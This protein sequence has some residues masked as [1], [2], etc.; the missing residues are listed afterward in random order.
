MVGLGDGHLITYVVDLGGSAAGG[1]PSLVSKRKG[2]LGSHSISFS[3]FRNGGELCVFASCD[4]PTVIYA[5]SGKLLF[6]VINS[7]KAEISGM[8]PF[9]SELFPDCLAMVSESSLLIGT[10][11]DIQKI[12]VQSIPLGEA[13]RRIAYNTAAGVY[14]GTLFHIMRCLSCLISNINYVQC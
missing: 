7:S 2:V 14:G 5:R 12:H 1:L 10:V 4:R 9:H 8:S 13:P 6:S 3:C 11:E